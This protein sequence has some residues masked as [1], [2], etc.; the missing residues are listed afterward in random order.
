VN[1]VALLKK[2]LNSS[3]FNSLQQNSNRRW[4]RPILDPCMILL[5]PH[6]LDRTTI[7]LVE[8]GLQDVG[9]DTL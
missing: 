8:S 6:P 9:P 2:L 1:P 3:K 7:D 5:L 4:M